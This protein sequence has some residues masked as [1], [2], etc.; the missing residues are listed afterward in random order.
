MSCLSRT[1]RRRS[2]VR[3]AVQHANGAVAPDGPVLSCRRGAR[4]ICN[5]SPTR[6]RTKGGDVMDQAQRMRGF[7]GWFLRPVYRNSLEVTGTHLPL[8]EEYWLALRH[9]AEVELAGIA[10][11]AAGDPGFTVRTPAEK[12]Q[13]WREFRA[14]VRQAEGFYRG[15]S[16][17]AWKSSPLNYYYSF[18]NLAKALAIVRGVLPPQPVHEPR[19]LHHGLSARVIAGNPDEWRLTVRGDDGVF[20]MLFRTVIGAPIPDN[21]ELEARRLLGY[22]LPIGWQLQKSGNG[23]LIAWFP[24][25]RIILV[26]AAECWDVIGVPREAPLDRLPASFSAAYEE[27][28]VDQAKAFAFTTLGLHASVA[29]ELRFLQ[30]KTPEVS[31]AAGECNAAALDRLLEES[32]P[33]CTFELLNGTDY[34]FGLGIPY[35]AAAS[36]VPINELVASYAVMYFLSSLV[37]YHPDYMD[38]IGESAEAWLIE[39]F[40]KSA[41][42]FLVRYLVAAVLGCTL[43]IKAN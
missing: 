12:N 3:A 27:I 2:F 21:T 33:H 29:S 9:P 38:R 23:A 15:A 35:A 11:L 18:M 40:A 7:T 31:A 26:Q 28:P 30:R 1:R 34:E 19:Q 37:R 24:C 41:P 20:P 4:L 6:V 8:D 39:S 13:L 25:H 42:L 22:S 32:A 5:V 43:I 17:L 10:L 14:Y 36:T 16:V